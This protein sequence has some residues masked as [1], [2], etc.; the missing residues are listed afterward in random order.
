M[1]SAGE[2][3]SIN[4]GGL[5]A[6]RIAG[7]ERQKPGFWDFADS[8]KRKGGHAFFQYPAMMVPELQGTLLDDLI[9]TD[10]SV[11]R[12]Y[13][14]FMGSG[15]VLLESIYRG[16][17][18]YG[19]DIN[20][21]AVLLSQVKAEPPLES[22]ATDAVN[23]VVEAAKR[24]RQ[25]DHDFTNIRKWFQPAVI[26]DLSR[27]R[28]SIQ[29]QPDLAIRRFLWICLAETIRLV[30]NSRTSTVKL[31]VYAAADL[32][33]RSP[34]TI[35]TFQ[36]IGLANAKGCGEHWA[37]FKEGALPAVYSLQR[38]SVLGDIVGPHEVDAI[39]T[40][41]PYG[42]ND[43]TVP[44][45]QHSYLPLQWIDAKDMVGTLEPSLLATTG[46]I[47]SLSLGGSIRGALNHQEEIARKSSTLRSYLA[48][49]DGRADLLKKVVSFSV[50]Y[51]MALGRATRSLRVGGFA[52]WTLGERRV[53]GTPVPLVK[54]TEDFLRLQKHETVQHITRLL[55]KRRRMAGANGLGETMSTEHVLITRRKA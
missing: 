44:Y 43:T 10:A 47:D 13:D 22:R 41:P 54:I 25:E 7:H 6:D 21:L 17:S 9:A 26:S 19:V 24:S 5:L 14:P 45:G 34:Q 29:L 1:L 33:A 15:T 38:G 28:R 4:I 31:H 49:I 36:L 37:H 16:L 3:T 8:G 30:S 42:D 50:D 55:P 12:V 23:E 52:F 11:K 18:F 27:L 20:P 53:G 2:P 35:P 48:K 46:R 39:M 40:S 51:E 32:A